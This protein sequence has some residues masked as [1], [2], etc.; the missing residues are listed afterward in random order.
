MSTEL[1]LENLLSYSLQLLGLVLAGG[2]LAWI[3]RIQVPRVV[4]LSWRLLLF[5]CCSPG[6]RQRFR[7]SYRSRV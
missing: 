4:H 1:W 7:R 2:I 6:P 3:F 5:L